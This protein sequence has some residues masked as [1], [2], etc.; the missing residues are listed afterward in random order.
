MDITSAGVRRKEGVRVIPGSRDHFTVIRDAL[1]E[2][3]TDSDALLCCAPRFPPLLVVLTSASVPRRDSSFCI[4]LSLTAPVLALAQGILLLDTS[5]SGI[6]CPFDEASD[7]FKHMFYFRSSR[8]VVGGPSEAAFLHTA[9]R[10]HPSCYRLCPPSTLLV[11][12]VSAVHGSVHLP[13]P[14]RIS[15]SANK[16]P[17]LDFPGLVH[18]DTNAI[19]GSKSPGY[20]KGMGITITNLNLLRVR[21]CSTPFTSSLDKAQV[22]NMT[23]LFETQP[24]RLCHLLHSLSPLPLAPWARGELL[25][26][27]C[28]SPAR[29]CPTDLQSAIPAVLSA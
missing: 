15:K 10:R 8:F 26:G 25:K 4:W 3:V 23:R 13:R 24:C 17:S 9:P 11:L 2:W 1:G 19:S 6:S 7:V 5:P 14:K 20:G 27:S 18:G 21:F 22:P 29:H 16:Y 28:L 12:L